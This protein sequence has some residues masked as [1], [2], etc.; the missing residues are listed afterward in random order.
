LTYDS[1]SVAVV[2]FPAT[3]EKALE[4]LSAL[5]AKHPGSHFQ[6]MVEPFILHNV[7]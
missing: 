5:F 1:L 2:L 7:I 6:P 4:L 3:P